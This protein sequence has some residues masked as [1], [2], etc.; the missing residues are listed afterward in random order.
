MPDTAASSAA[1][2][3][4]YD[5][6]RQRQGERRVTVS[7]YAPDD[8]S[9]ETQALRA[10]IAKEMREAGRRVLARHVASS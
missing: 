5:G 10:E 4:D 6:K 7:L 8:P 2:V 1:R 9:P 3:A